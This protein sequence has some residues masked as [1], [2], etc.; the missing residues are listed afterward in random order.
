M[1]G[2]RKYSSG[3]SQRQSNSIMQGYMKKKACRQRV[4]AG[5]GS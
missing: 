2:N 4:P 3:N 1:N 5:I